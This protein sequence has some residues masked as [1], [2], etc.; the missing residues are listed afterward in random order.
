M[1]ADEIKSVTIKDGT[2][3]ISAKREEKA[4]FTV[5]PSKTPAEIDITPSDKGDKLRGIYQT[6]ETEKGFELTIT[7]A[8]GKAVR[9]KDFKGEG[10]DTAVFKLLRKKEK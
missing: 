2:I 1:A 4:S 5:D 7:F 9:P 6:K 8:N 10:E 3:T